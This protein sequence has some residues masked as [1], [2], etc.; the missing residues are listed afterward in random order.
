M[1]TKHLERLSLSRT[2]ITILICFLFVS[3]VVLLCPDCIASLFGGTK[4]LKGFGEG[5]ENYMI[6]GNIIHLGPEGKICL[7]SRGT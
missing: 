6:S 7:K 3:E 1:E 5:L 4:G 2:L